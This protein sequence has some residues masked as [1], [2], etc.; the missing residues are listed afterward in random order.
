MARNEDLAQEPPASINPYGVLGVEEKATADAIKSAYR[1]KALKHHPDKLPPELKDEANKKFQEIAF[2]YAILSDE[3]RR[4]R[5][6][7]TGSTAETLDLEDDDFDWVDFYREQFSSMVDTDAIEKIKKEYQGSEEE[8]NDL[9]AAFDKYEGN[10]D[11][12]YETVM[13]SNVL[14]DDAR[15]RAII[16]SA[17]AEGKVKKWK[18]YTEESDQ[19]KEQRLKRAQSEAKEAE[20]MAKELE[21]KG[22]KKKKTATSDMNDLAGLIQKRQSNRAADFLDQLEAKYAQS[23]KGLEKGK[24]R[25]A[26]CDEPPKEAFQATAARMAASKKKKAKT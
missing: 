10:M 23:T 19:K 21:S 12:V 13:L 15:F 5:Y 9:L 25:P 22:K 24:K 16:D 4:R 26:G 3:Q 18:K 1:K 11:Q 20:Q 2:A 7:L 6:D 8:Q 17:I 14:D